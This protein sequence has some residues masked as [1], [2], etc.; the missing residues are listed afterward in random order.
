MPSRRI[1]IIYG[2]SY[3]Q[4]AKIARRIA[5]TFTDWG[6]AVTRLDADELRVPIDVRAYDG[7]VIGASVIR[8]RHRPAV[9]AFVRQNA[10]ALNNMPTAFF[11]VSGSAASPDERGRAEARRCVEKFL[12]Q[13][14]WRPAITEMIGGAMAYTKYGVILR[15]IMKQIAKQSGAPTDTSRDHEL[16]DWTQ[17][18]NLAARFEARLGGSPSLPPEPA[19]ATGSSVS[20]SALAEKST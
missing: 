2:T 5:E 7:V 11:S 6:E 1:L 20:A 19:A 9:E 14:R 16:T 18:W 17:V 4:T 8:G 3:G 15:W 12:D 13:T 10:S